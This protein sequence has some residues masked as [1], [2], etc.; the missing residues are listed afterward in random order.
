M[1]SIRLT[2]AERQTLLDHYRRAA[3]PAG[4]HRAHI[5]LLLGAGHPWATISAVLFRST[6]TISRWKRRFEILR[7]EGASKWFAGSPRWLRDA[8]RGAPSGKGNGRRRALTPTGLVSVGH[9]GQRGVPDRR[10]QRNSACLH[11]SM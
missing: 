10:A 4:G 1:T 9:L 11:V 5:L 6:S 2:T 8:H 7:L 3:D